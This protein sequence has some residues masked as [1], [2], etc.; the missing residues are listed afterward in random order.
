[1]KGKLDRSEMSEE[2]GFALICWPDNG[3]RKKP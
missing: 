1:M 3:R 2:K